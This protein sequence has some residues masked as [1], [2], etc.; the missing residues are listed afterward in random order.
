[1]RLNAWLA[2]IVQQRILKQFSIINEHALQREQLI[3]TPRK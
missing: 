2:E 3:A 1:M